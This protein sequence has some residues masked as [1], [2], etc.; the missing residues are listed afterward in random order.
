[1]NFPGHISQV[2]AFIPHE[3]FNTLCN[4]KAQSERSNFVIPRMSDVRIARNRISLLIQ[5]EGIEP[6]SLYRQKILSLSCLPIS[7]SLRIPKACGS[8]GIITDC[9]S[10]HVATMNESVCSKGEFTM[11]LCHSTLSP[12]HGNNSFASSRVPLPACLFCILHN[13]T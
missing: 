1:M 5:G 13:F 8:L 9:N 6:S 7:P 11:P 4:S 10:N 3:K 2:T 12:P